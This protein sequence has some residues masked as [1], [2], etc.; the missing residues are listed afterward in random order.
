MCL[1]FTGKTIET[2]IEASP[3]NGLEPAL[4]EKGRMS[5]SNRLRPEVTFERNRCA[6]GWSDIYDRSTNPVKSHKKMTL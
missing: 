3:I 1:R 5:I 2:N 4:H 6:S